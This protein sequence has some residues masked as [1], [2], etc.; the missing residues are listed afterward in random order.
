MIKAAVLEPVFA[1]RA[2]CDAKFNLS[3]TGS[4]AFFNQMDA[5]RGLKSA[6]K[7]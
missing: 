3:A 5:L 2:T 1:F 7:Q 6:L 4:G